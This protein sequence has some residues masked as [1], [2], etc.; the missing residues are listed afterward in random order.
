MQRHPARL[1]FLAA[2]LLSP[3]VSAA[4]EPAPDQRV[5]LISAF[6]PQAPPLQ[7]QLDNKLGPALK[8]TLELVPFWSIRAW[9]TG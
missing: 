6:K 3:T 8:A 1:L 2:A 4:T 7:T 5:V 9:C